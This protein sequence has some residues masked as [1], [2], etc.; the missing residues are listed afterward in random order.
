VDLFLFGHP[1]DYS[2]YFLGA[3]LLINQVQLPLKFH[4]LVNFTDVFEEKFLQVPL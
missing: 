2:D 3:C 4:R 1:I